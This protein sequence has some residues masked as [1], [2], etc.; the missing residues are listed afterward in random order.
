MNSISAAVNHG[1]IGLCA[2][3]T[4]YECLCIVV[5]ESGGNYNLYFTSFNYDCVGDAFLST[6]KW[7]YVVLVFDAASLSRSTYINEKLDAA[8]TPFQGTL[9]SITTGDVCTLGPM[10]R[11]NHFQGCTDQLIMNDRAKSSYEILQE[12]TLSRCVTFY[13]GMSSVDPGPNSLPG[14]G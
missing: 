8:G 10:S 1:I 6:N 12:A 11:D 3:V 4:T 5:C 7:I 13:S 2:G 9:D 14:A